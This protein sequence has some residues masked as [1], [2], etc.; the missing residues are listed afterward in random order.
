ML[1]L[2]KKL[3]N[4]KRYKKVIILVLLF[5]ILLVVLFNIFFMFSN[6]VSD[7]M[8]NLLP[9]GTKVLCSKVVNDINRGDIVV[10]NSHEE[11]KVMIKRVIGLPNEQVTIKDGNVYIDGLL[12]KE[13][14]LQDG[15]KTEGNVDIHIPT[16]C[17]FLLGDNRTLSNDGRSWS[18]KTVKR[19]DIVAKVIMIVYPFDK[20]KI[21]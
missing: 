21:L 13:N 2:L 4:I 12:L 1:E 6:V 11:D 8:S 17:Y 19:G 15:M 14:Y 5:I 18:I 10:F 16:N 9:D 20:M 3:K 7:S